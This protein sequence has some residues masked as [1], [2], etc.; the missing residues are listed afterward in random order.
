MVD[1]ALTS[2]CSGSVAA[3]QVRQE[4]LEN[5]PEVGA[6]AGITM[7]GAGARTDQLRH[8]V[9]EMVYFV[10]GELELTVENTTRTAQA[11]QFLT[12]PRECW[13][14][15]RNDS[16]APARMLYVFAVSAPRTDRR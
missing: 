7:M 16:G 15:F 2:T 13:H 4:I 11:G 1:H 8:D 6:L 9:E 10:E 12:I 3:G 14:S 5:R